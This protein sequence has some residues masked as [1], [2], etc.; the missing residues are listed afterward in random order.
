MSKI[1]VSCFFLNGKGVDVSIDKRGSFEWLFKQLYNKIRGERISECPEIK[2]SHKIFLIYDKGQS[3]HIVKRGFL[4]TRLE[5]IG[6]PDEESIVTL[7]IENNSEIHIVL[8]DDEDY[9][10]PVIVLP[11]RKYRPKPKP[12]EED[13]HFYDDEYG[14]L[15]NFLDRPVPVEKKKKGKKPSLT[16]I[17]QER[18]DE[19]YEDYG[20]THEYIANISQK[21]ERRKNKNRR[22]RQLSRVSEY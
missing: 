6:A 20:R 21:L 16:L 18:D 4:N 9:V 13:H 19:D 22:S 15:F 7:G 1:T 12:V 8:L 11:P 14:F 3:E 10:A 17:D 5:P 2:D